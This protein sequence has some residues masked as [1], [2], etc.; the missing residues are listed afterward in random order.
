[1][2]PVLH[3]EGALPV[4]VLD[5]EELR[6][7]MLAGELRRAYSEGDVTSDPNSRRSLYESTGAKR[8][9]L[10]K[11]RAAHRTSAGIALDIG[12]LRRR[13]RRNH[14]AP[15]SRAFRMPSCDGMRCS[16]HG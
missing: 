9:R 1:M 4:R 13:I 7:S 3:L 2:Y 5:I 11:S 12:I 6:K 10:S 15:I 8:M 16:A 14:R